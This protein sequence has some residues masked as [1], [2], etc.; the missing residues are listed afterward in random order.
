MDSTSTSPP[1]KQIVYVNLRP[2]TT[3]SVV[4]PMSTCHSLRQTA[5][6][7][8][9][10]N[11]TTLLG[12]VVVG[13]PADRRGDPGPEHS[14]RSSLHFARFQ[15]RQD[16]GVHTPHTTHNHAS[17]CLALAKRSIFSRLLVMGGAISMPYNCLFFIFCFSIPF[18]LSKSLAFVVVYSHS[19]P[20]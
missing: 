15:A 6:S 4:A 20:F 10:R 1:K 7:A 16:D 9:K 17:S 14:Q 12:R 8:K 3:P 18:Q 19:D 11:T 2:S 13:G 5:R